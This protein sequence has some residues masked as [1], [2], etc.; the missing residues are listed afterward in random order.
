M[1]VVII[2]PN[3]EKS[4]AALIAKAKARPTPLATVKANA[5]SAEQHD[6]KFSDRKPG[7]EQRPEDHLALGNVRVAFSIEEQPVGMCA[8]L[9][10]SVSKPGKVPGPAAVEMIA[11][12]FGM[13]GA[14]FDGKKHFWLE[15]FEPGHNAVNV[16]WLLGAGAEGHA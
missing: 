16:V 11:S 13:K 4:I 1:S 10:L 12:A 14:V 15:E 5:V 9:S 8:H 3:E 7:T 6:V 2:G